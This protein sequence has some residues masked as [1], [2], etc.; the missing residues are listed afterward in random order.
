[1]DP[2]QKTLAGEQQS[3]EAVDTCAQIKCSCIREGVTECPC[4]SSSSCNCQ[5][6]HPETLRSHR[7]TE[8]SAKRLSTPIHNE[9][10][11]C[12]GSGV[13]CS[14]TDHCTCGQA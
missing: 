11:A 12:H 6:C 1:M 3:G 9:A 5:S 2:S 4:V 7:E 14:C 13:G 10:C 8:E